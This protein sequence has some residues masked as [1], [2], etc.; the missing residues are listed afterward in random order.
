MKDSELSS[1]DREMNKKEKEIIK[2]IL[3]YSEQFPSGFYEVGDFDEFDKSP[4]DM[5]AFLASIIR[6]KCLYLLNNSIA[7]VG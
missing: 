1:G 3:Y 2:Q 7:V 5:M 6:K 4:E